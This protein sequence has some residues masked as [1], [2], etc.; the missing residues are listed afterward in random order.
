MYVARLRYIQS[1]H[2]SRERRN[3]DALVRHFLPTLQRWRA[4][5]L[6]REELA[7]LRGD[8]FYYYLVARTKYYDEVFNDAVSAGVQQIVSVGCGSDTRPYRFKDLL[9]SKGVR[10]LECD[11]PEAIQVEQIRAE[12]GRDKQRLAGQ[13]REKTIADQPVTK[14]RW[15]EAERAAELLSAEGVRC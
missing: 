2:E 4:T 6:G 5:W 8:P 1:I 3:P 11:Q 13:P 10:V 7:R 14:V 15:Q 12:R 9:C